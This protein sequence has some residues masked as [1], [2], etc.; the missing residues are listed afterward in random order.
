MAAPSR[1][2]LEVITL[3]LS[4]ALR[5]ALGTAT[6]LIIRE[7]RQCSQLAKGKCSY[8]TYPVLLSILPSGFHVTATCSSSKEI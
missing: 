5:G 2:A 3:T 1:K 8:V 4:A 7:V 6:I